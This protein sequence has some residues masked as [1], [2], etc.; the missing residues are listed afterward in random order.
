MKNGVVVLRGRRKLPD[1]TTVL[2]TVKA[3]SRKRR[4]KA[5]RSTL[6]DKLL[7]LAGAAG[8]GLPADLARNHD[9]YLYGVPKK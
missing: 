9:H 4:A 2:V 5:N 7:K 6:A 1:G 8:P 3:V